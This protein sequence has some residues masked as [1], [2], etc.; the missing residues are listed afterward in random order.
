MP[1]DKGAVDR[2]SCGTLA[3]LPTASTTHMHQCG[4][5]Y[6]VNAKGIRSQEDTGDV[7]VQGEHG[8]LG[9][10]LVTAVIVNDVRAAQW[11]R[12]P[13]WVGI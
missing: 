1:T 9:Q 2:W 12:G 10:I 11:T 3:S 8:M 4:P 13:R 5:T 7:G 6:R